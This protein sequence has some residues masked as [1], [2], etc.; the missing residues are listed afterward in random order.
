M[1]TLATLQTRSG[2]KS[3]R[4]RRLLKRTSSGQ[5]VIEVAL[6]ITVILLLVVG[7]A[8]FP[9][10][11]VRT[12]QLTQAV[13]EGV[14]YGRTAPTDTFGIRKRVVQTVPAIY[15][16]PTDAQITAMTSSQIGV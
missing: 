14:A 9:P 5:A 12:A 11:V 16:S 13:R 1:T 4:Q 6:G 10:P 3:R 15:G 2:E 7:L 8:E